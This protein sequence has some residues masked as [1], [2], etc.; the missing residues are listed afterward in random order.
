MG[1]NKNQKALFL[2]KI[3]LKR[4]SGINI[5]FYIPWIQLVSATDLLFG[6]EGKLR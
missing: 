5:H 3:S 1:D 6:I 4:L 2:I